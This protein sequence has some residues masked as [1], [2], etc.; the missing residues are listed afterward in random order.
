MVIKIFTDGA[1]SRNP[2]PGGW[3]YIICR[4]EEILKCSGSSGGITTNNRME[5]M[6]VIKAL[7][8]VT[9]LNEKVFKIFSDS[10]YVINAINNN[11]WVERWQKNGWKTTKGE[12]VKNCDLWKQLMENMYKC[13]KQNKTLKFEKVKGHAGN[14][15]NELV[16]TMA[17]TEAIKQIRG[18]RV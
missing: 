14:Y 11:G 7:E 6:A 13:K 17:R 12:D 9:T 15:F 5:L 16:D 8:K 3:S 1:C 10:A 2:G 18:E 4:D